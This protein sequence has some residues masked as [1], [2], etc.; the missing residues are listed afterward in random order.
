[1]DQV[2]NT[3]RDAVLDKVVREE[4]KWGGVSLDNGCSIPMS[5]GDFIRFALK[6]VEHSHYLP[7]PPSRK[8][9]PANEAG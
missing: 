6:N 2:A 5:D 3:G 4:I 7:D 1:M 9:H 8:R